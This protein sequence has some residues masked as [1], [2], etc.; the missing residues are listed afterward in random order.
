MEP[1]VLDQITFN[2]SFEDAAKIN[3]IRP[4]SRS[5][6]DFG[7][8][9]ED[10]RLIA[11]PKAMYMVTQ[12]GLKDNHHVVLNGSTFSSR[13]LHVNLSGVH[14][15]FP[16]VI[17]CGIELYEWKMSFQ[18]SLMQYYADMINSV[19]L[20][21]AIEHVI[22]HLTKTYQLGE[23]SAMN[24][25]SLEDWPINQQIPLFELVGNPEKSIGVQLSD[26]LLMIPNQSV[27]GIRFQND[28]GYT[29]CELCP[30]ETCPSRKARYDRDL[31]E[32]KFT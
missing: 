13:V 3:K 15:V 20:H 10:A 12:V 2:P 24:P 14:R 29:N 23:P 30:M 31:Y 4:E 1:I 22:S 11:K 25:G 8:L 27:S 26:S 28:S 6:D 17:T 5:A 9:L 21:V 32:R 19:A 18:D 16:Y 7:T